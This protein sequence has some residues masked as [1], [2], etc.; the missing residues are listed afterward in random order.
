MLPEKKAIIKVCERAERM[1]D[2]R[3]Y[4][5][6]RLHQLL[7]KIHDDAKARSVALDVRGHDYWDE[8]A[9]A[10]TPLR[11]TLVAYKAKKY[12][13]EPTHEINKQ[14]DAFI[15]SAKDAAKAGR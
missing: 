8:L 1:L 11:S 4:R 2:E 12:A 3:R 15:G 14:K 9:D 13:G 5:D 6:K 7:D 10:T